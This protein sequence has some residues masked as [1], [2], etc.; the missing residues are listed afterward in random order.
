M[1]HALPILAR[2]VVT[3]H[4]FQAAGL[5]PLAPPVILFEVVHSGVYTASALVT[6]PSLLFGA[7]VVLLGCRWYI[8]L[9]H[10]SRLPAALLGTLLLPAPSPR[11]FFQK[12]QRRAAGR[13]A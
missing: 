8:P 13:V 1:G 9:G 4:A 6:L 10:T 12:N 5:S 2:A 3:Q 7:W 11:F